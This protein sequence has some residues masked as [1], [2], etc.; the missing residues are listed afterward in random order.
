M[1]TARLRAVATAVALVALVALVG[2]AA[3]LAARE[4]A[5]PPTTTTTTTTTVGLSTVAAAIAGSL[6]DDLGAPLSSDEAHCLAT[7]LLAVL[8]PEEL[9]VLSSLAAPLT[10]LEPE[11]REELLRGVVRCVPSAT[12][13]A[14]LASGTTTTVAVELPDEGT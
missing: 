12:A 1:T 9:V 3:F 5:P 10:A 7:A 2:S 14:L 13:A 6:Q 8:S 11:E 4:E